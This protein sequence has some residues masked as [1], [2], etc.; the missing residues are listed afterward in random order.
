MW[1]GFTKSVEGLNRTQ[2]DS[3]KQE[4]ILST[5]GLWTHLQLSP[6]SLACW[7]LLSYFKLTKPPQLHEPIP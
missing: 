4:G 2:T 7:P 5:D 6:G 3:T 1:V